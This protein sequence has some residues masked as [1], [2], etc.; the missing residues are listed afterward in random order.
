[1]GHGTARHG[2]K[3]LRKLVDE[4]MSEGAE[5]CRVHRKR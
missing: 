1:M 4:L 3:K 5:R 2:F